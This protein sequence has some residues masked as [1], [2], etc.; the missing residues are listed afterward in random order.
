ML[1]AASCVPR[2]GTDVGNGFTVK[3]NMQGYAA[4]SVPVTQA[5]HP[6]G[7]ELRNGVMIDSVWAT[8][9]H[10]RLRPGGD[11]SQPDNAVDIKGPL[12]A[13]LGGSGFVGGSPVFHTTSTTFCELALEFDI[14]G[15]GSLP[16]GAP[17]ELAGAS[18]V[19]E[20]KRSDGVPF[21]V[22]STMNGPLR[23]DSQQGSFS[24]GDAKSSVII[25][26]DMTSAVQALDLD[27]LAGNPIVVDDFTNPD[28]LKA[29]ETA[30]REASGLFRDLNKD[31]RLD[32]ND[33]SS[34]NELGRG[35][36]QP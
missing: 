6:L 25:G 27:T 35:S 14:L 33:T 31:G 24:L 17:P 26:V 16:A 4:S 8:T 19:V 7:L 23:I 22:R 2:A 3:L 29:F 11:C 30:V 18:M 34:D 15:S 12:V 13:N 32:A 10:F 9:S 21:V 1:L 36:G 20:G 28:K 5:V